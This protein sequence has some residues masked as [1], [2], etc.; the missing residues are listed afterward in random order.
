M[1]DLEKLGEYLQPPGAMLGVS[2]IGAIAGAIARSANSDGD[3]F[4]QFAR[5]FRDAGHKDHDAYWV[6][7]ERSTGAWR[8]TTPLAIAGIADELV[9]LLRTGSHQNQ[10]DA[11]VA[12]ILALATSAASRLVAAANDPIVHEPRTV[13]AAWTTNALVREVERADGSWVRL[14]DGKHLI[15]ASS[16]L[17]NVPLGHGHP[18]PLA[19]FIAQCA[20]G[21][22]LNPFTQTSAV[23]DSLSDRLTRLANLQGG[24][25]FYC[26]SG[27]E[28]VEVAFRLSLAICGQ[29]SLVWAQP[30]AFHGASMG[31]AMLTSFPSVWREFKRMER[32]VKHAPPNAWKAPGIGFF[33]PIRVGG[34]VSRTTGQ[35]ALRSFHAAGGLLIADEIACGL[36]RT[37][38]P[39]A[40]RQLDIPYDILLL[41]KGL[42]NGVVPLSCV[43]MSSEVVE[44]LR[45]LGTDFGHT[46]SNHLGGAAAA[47][48]ALAELE[49]LDHTRFGA[50]LA[51][52][53]A[54][55][56]PKARIE[57]SIAAVDL[58]RPHE[59]SAV[60]ECL[61][62]AGLA[63]HLPTV[64]QDVRHLTIAPPLTTDDAT[65]AEL[66]IRLRYTLE[67]LDARP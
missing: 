4:K 31:A 58:K 23:L 7:S 3:A 6:P 22:T 17:W 9:N 43:V 42:T 61:Y 46:H 24:R 18:A 59:R 33:E 30:G 37:Y 62:K 51:T 15:D 8:R 48:G 16:G 52:A 55:V 47:Q 50:A 32:F 54:G 41:G 1:I 49:R 21:P 63:I 65:L 40:A 60:D 66:A 27:S 64:A 12:R 25:V 13:P 14:R 35:D 53:V 45:A 34:G 44:R 11:D 56:E 19:E 5:Q 38:W 67:L 39:L 29:E 57:G 28:A 2:E 20:I 10:T 36:G 26:S